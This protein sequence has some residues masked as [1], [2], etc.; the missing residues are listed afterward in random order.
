MEWQ[1]DFTLPCA[2]LECS[3][4]L[5]RKRRRTLPY[6]QSLLHALLRLV[7]TYLYISSPYQ[8]YVLISTHQYK[9]FTKDVAASKSTGSQRFTFK[10]M[11]YDLLSVLYVTPFYIIIQHLCDFESPTTS[12]VCPENLGTVPELGESVRGFSWTGMASAVVASPSGTEFR[13][14]LLVEVTLLS[15]GLPF[16]RICE[17]CFF[18]SASVPG[19]RSGWC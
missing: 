1:S 12:L 16:V 15:T 13:L 18:K 17:R 5:F 19:S 10:N 14:W 6:L 2:S 7:I 4:T 3:I 8:T 11:Y 9:H